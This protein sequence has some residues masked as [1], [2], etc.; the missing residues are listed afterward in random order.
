MLIVIGGAH[1]KVGKTKFIC[2]LAE[3][4]KDVC[5]IKCSISEK[6]ID[7]QIIRDKESLD[8]NGKDTARYMRAGISNVLLIRANSKELFRVLDDIKILS[9]RYSYVLVEGNSIAEYI[10]PDMI[11]YIGDDNSSDRTRGSFITERKAD[12]KIKAFRNH[13]DDVLKEIN[14]RYIAIKKKI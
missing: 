13:I 4:L 12:I 2:K 8:L 9:S 7:M 11:I 6:I 3:N 5:A 10:D 14:K 1:S